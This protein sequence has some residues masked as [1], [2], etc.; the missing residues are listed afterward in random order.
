MLAPYIFIFRL[1]VVLYIYIIASAPGIFIKY[2]ANPTGLIK[3]VVPPGEAG[4]A[5]V[6]A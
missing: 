1:I 4:E 2:L 5:Q 3:I 6:R